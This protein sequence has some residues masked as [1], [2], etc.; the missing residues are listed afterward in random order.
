MEVRSPGGR[1]WLLIYLPKLLPLRLCP[2]VLSDSDALSYPHLTAN[3]QSP[4]KIQLQMISPK[5]R[6]VV[7]L[8]GCHQGGKPWGL[9]VMFYFLR[10]RFILSSYMPFCV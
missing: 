6:W 4:C 1:S 5:S 8:G 3:L 9:F 2:A 7:H 10:R